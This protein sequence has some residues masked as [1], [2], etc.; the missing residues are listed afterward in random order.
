MKG[1]N[2]LPAGWKKRENGGWEYIM[3]P[4][5]IKEMYRKKRTIFMLSALNIIQA[6]LIIIMTLSHFYS[7]Q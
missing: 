3:F 2:D 4:F 6:I 7:Q 5:E 1:D